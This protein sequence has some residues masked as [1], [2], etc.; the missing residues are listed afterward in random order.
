MKIGR[1]T[2][3]PLRTCN[4]AQNL[5]MNNNKQQERN[6]VI[7]TERR[8]K[9]RINQLL[10]PLVDML[11]PGHEKFTCQ[12][13][14]LFTD[15]GNLTLDNSFDIRFSWTSIKSKKSVLT[16]FSSHSK[17]I[18]FL[19]FSVFYLSNNCHCHATFKS[20]TLS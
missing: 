15:G 19:R 20:V 9:E 17:P 16:V 18:R 8:I 2:G 13:W 14:Q 4:F 7:L 11:T 12:V 6:I 5:N 3:K 1:E 10:W